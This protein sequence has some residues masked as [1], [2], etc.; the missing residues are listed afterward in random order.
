MFGT[1]GVSLAPAIRYEDN[2]LVCSP[3]LLIYDVSIFEGYAW[4]RRWELA[5]FFFVSVL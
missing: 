5:E 1:L 2:C 4:A 3:S